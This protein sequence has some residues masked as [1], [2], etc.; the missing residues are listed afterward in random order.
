MEQ[1]IWKD[2]PGYEGFYS[3]S[4]SGRVKSLNRVIWGKTGRPKTIHERILI[5]RLDVNGYEVVVLCRCGE[6]NNKK[7]HRLVAMSFIPNPECKPCVDHINGNRR[8]NRV[9]NLRWCTNKENDN[10]ELAKK[11]RSEC[12]IGERAA[13]FGKFGKE[14]PRS[15]RVAQYGMDG[16]FIKLYYALSDASRQTGIHLGNISSA[17][18]GKYKSAGGYIWRFVNGTKFE[19]KTDITTDPQQ[20]G[21]D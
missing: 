4:S 5:P 9:E 8:D 21:S 19:D 15:R 14:N 3:V 1:E 12:R 16:C 10:Y 18:N 17:C 20:C 7:V 13:W 6:L 2:I 11:H